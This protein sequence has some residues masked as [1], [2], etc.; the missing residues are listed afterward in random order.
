VLDSCRI[1]WGRVLSVH[2]GHAVVSGAPLHWTGREL[3]LGPPGPQTVRVAPTLPV[4]V[5]DTVALHWDWLCDVLTPRQAATL[6]RYTASQLDVANR[7]LARP[8]A[9]LV[10]R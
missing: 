7:T 8:V 2:S 6:R 10:L 1:R 5:G 3:V 9:D 4:A